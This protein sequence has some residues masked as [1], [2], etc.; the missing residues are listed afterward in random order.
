TVMGRRLVRMRPLALLAAVIAVLAVAQAGSGASM[1]P[2]FYCTGGQITIFDNWTGGAVWN[3]GTQPTL[4]TG[5]TAY[6]V[7]SI[8]TYHWN[9]GVG[10]S[11]PGT[12]GLAPIDA[13]TGQGGPWPVTVTAATNGVP[14]NWTATPSPGPV[15]IQGLYRCVDSHPATWSQASAPPAPPGPGFCRVL[16]RRAVRDS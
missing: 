1:P 6:C 4:N 11:D 13:I 9:D 2:G 7:D 14:A 16:G 5:S 8:S 15:V 3:G 12:I 10:D